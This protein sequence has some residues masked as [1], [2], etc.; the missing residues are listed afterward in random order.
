VKVSHL[1]LVAVMRNLTRYPIARLNTPAHLTPADA[2]QLPIELVITIAA[3][4]HAP[5]RVV[6]D[7]RP[8]LVFAGTDEQAENWRST[9]HMTPDRFRRVQSVDDVRDLSPMDWQVALVGTWKRDK[10]VQEAAVFLAERAAT[11]RVL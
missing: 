8:W 5:H 1:N 6:V 2:L 9:N 10:A 3:A 7:A 4:Q 11:S